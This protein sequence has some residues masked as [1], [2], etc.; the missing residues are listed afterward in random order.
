MGLV[1]VVTTMNEIAGA[2]GYGRI[3][4]VENRLV[5]VKS[6]ECYETPAAL[7]IIVAHKALEDLCLEREVL[8]YKLALEQKW[9]EAV[10]YGQW[11]GPLKE[12]L[13]AFMDSTQKCLMG[14]V[15]LKFY[16]G[17]CTVVGSKSPFSL[18]DYGLATYDTG[19]DFNHKAAA[20]FIDLYGL[21]AKTWAANRA[22]Y[23]EKTNLSDAFHAASPFKE[24]SPLSGAGSKVE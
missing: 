15:R 3:D 4:M 2:N 1:D 5:G 21:S 6:R 8:H 13:D 19:D 24:D 14:T 9:A 16:K 7:S 18:Y 20:G 11:F 12:A 23:G 17:T 10:Y 22:K